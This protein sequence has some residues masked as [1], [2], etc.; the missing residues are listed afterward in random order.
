MVA[1]LACS[2]GGAFYGVLTASGALSAILF[3]VLYGSL[4]ALIGAPVGFVINMTRH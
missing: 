2:L 4:G 3:G 1:V